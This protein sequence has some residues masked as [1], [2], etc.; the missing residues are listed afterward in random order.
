MLWTLAA[1]RIPHKSARLATRAVIGDRRGLQTMDTNAWTGSGLLGKHILSE[2]AGGSI[3]LSIQNTIYI[4]LV[5]WFD[6]IDDR[7][8]ILVVQRR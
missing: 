1:P 5:V 6:L 2:S 7:V 3:A 8:D 4:R